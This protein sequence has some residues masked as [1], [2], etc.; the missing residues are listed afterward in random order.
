MDRGRTSPVKVAILDTGADLTHPDREARL[1]NIKGKY[2]W[3]NENL[4]KSVHDRNGHGTFT[5]GLLLDYAPDAHLYIAKIAE[6]K[7]PSP[8]IIAKVFSCQ[9]Y[10]NNSRI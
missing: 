5:A 4:K 7:P 9:D 3:L 6:N 2:N 1:E 10:V 8:R